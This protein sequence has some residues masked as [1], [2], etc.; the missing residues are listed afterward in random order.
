MA[1]ETV[2]ALIEGGKASAAPPLGPALGPL[3]VNIGQVIA[4]INKKTDSFKGMQVPIKVEVDKSS[5][6]FTVS[7]GTPPTSALIKK[8]ASIQKGSGKPHAEKVADLAIE[9]II[10]ISKM[11]DDDLHGKTP[12][13]R[14]KEVIGTC[15]SMGVLV[16][17]KPAVDALKDVDAGTYDKEIASGK[18]ELSAEEK[19]QLEEER[20][21]MQES[22]K[23]R[24]D[25]I[26]AK[27]TAIVDAGKKGSKDAN[28]IRAELAAAGIPDDLID[29]FQPKAK[30]APSDKD[31]GGGAKGGKK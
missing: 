3:G 21:V 10:K 5:K 20:K 8:E 29:K 13:A 30:A 7:V 16:E 15:N 27:A 19:R 12:K 23:K 2:E 25:E 4:E 24:H 9:Q 17:G 18:T 28:A 14:V 26:T 22:L 1:T 11:K 31:K 6:E